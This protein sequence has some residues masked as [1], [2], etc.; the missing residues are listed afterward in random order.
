MGFWPN[1][2]EGTHHRSS[3]FRRCYQ[4]VQSKI[5]DLFVLPEDEWDVLLVPL[6]GSLAIEAL[7]RTFGGTVNVQTHGAF[8]ERVGKVHQYSESPWS[9]G[10]LHE[11]NDSRIC[12]VSNCDI[13]DAVSA[14]PYFEFP[15]QAQAVVTVSS[16]QFCA[17]TIWS[18]VF[19]RT[20][21]WRHA[22][23][24]TG[25]LNLQRY[26]EF[27]RIFETPCTP[28]IS[29]LL[30]F[31]QSLKT[32]NVSTFRSK[33]DQRYTKLRK[34][35][36]KLGGEVKGGPPAFTFRL[37]DH[38]MVRTDQFWIPPGNEGWLQAFL[39]SGSDAEYDQLVTYL[40][41]F[42]DRQGHLI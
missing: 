24:L 31:E 1:S 29:A 3:E 38:V 14:L 40:S 18:V 28:P 26:K 2:K 42:D 35:I 22:Q 32:F 41:N 39:W 16:K 37:P 8:S 23:P 13:V 6:N 11:T 20:D 17:E 27:S 12:D 30:S 36:L 4:S 9:F 15:R 25:Y 19:V 10:V 7:I 34:S 21:F 5:R 33:I